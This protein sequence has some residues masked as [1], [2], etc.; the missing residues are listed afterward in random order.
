MIHPSISAWTHHVLTESLT[1]TF[2]VWIFVF[3]YEFLM[4]REKKNIYIL[5]LILVFYSTIRDV[6]AYYVVSF[7]AIFIILFYY[8]YISKLTFIVVGSILILSFLF[9]N[10]TANNARNTIE[11]N[12]KMTFQANGKTIASRWMFP[13]MNIMGHVVLNN[14]VLFE[15]MKKEGMPVNDALLKHK[16]AWGGQGW[17]TDPDLQDIRDWVVESGKYTYMKFL[18]T[19][20]R[21]T[22]GRIYLHRHHVFH[23]SMVEQK[24]FYRNY[25][26]GYKADNIFTYST[27]KNM[28]IY[29][30]LFFVLLVIIFFSLILRKTIFNIHTIPILILLLPIGLLAIVTYHGDAVDLFRHTLIVPFLIKTTMFMLIYVLGNEL[31]SKKN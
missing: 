21:Y 25:L 1:F 29:K 6:N 10:Y 22:F 9:S 5:L 26:P 8:K 28:T 15:Y 24:W 7:I 13:F 17:Y 3:L 4:S 27:I 18:I 11:N 12:E 20:P 16:N 30:I 14:P 23:Y 2:M 31:F 19:H